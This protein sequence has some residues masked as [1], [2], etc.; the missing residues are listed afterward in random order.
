MKIIFHLK[1]QFYLVLISL[2]NIKLRYSF[3]I[4]ITPI[5]YVKHI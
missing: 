2:F 4:I 1:Y 3:N 5:Y